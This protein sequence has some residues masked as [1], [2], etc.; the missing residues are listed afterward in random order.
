MIR[1]TYCSEASDFVYCN[2][3]ECACNLCPRRGAGRWRVYGVA[4]SHTSTSTSSTSSN[5]GGER[6]ELLVSGAFLSLI[7]S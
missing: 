4:F 7:K 6:R 5:A 2:Y 3:Y 1:T